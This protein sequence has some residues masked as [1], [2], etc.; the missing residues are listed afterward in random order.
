MADVTPI[1]RDLD[2]EQDRLQADA[3]ARV[4]AQVRTHDGHWSD[5]DSGIADRIDKRFVVRT[6]AIA[7]SASLVLSAAAIA[8]LR[9]AVGDLGHQT[10]S[11]GAM[12]PVLVALASFL[13]FVLTVT[14]EAPKLKSESLYNCLSVSFLHIAVISAITMIDLASNYLNGPTLAS[15]FPGSGLTAT[16]IG[17]F[18]A[19]WSCVG[20]FAGCFIASGLI[21]SQADTHDVVRVAG[22]H[23][24]HDIGT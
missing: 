8:V 17:F 15:L 16:G 1:R 10:G 22:G 5:F 4:A 2:H 24:A 7:A 18:T 9:L 13:A 23:E 3:E 11:N 19:Q 20:S 14:H 12:V 21:E 6:W